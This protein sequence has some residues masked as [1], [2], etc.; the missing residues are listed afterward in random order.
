MTKKNHSI[1]DLHQLINGCE[2]IIT[3]IIFILDVIDNDGLQL[4]KKWIDDDLLT[5]SDQSTR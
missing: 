4:V 3:G 1:E 5:T 2:W